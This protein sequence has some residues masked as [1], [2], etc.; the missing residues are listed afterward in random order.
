MGV[1]EGKGRSRPLSE[2]P[3][4]WA[5]DTVPSH[6]TGRDE[7]VSKMLVAW[8]GSELHGARCSGVIEARVNYS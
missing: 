3:S 5:E 1:E 4:R 6:V 8:D 7:Y 2:Y